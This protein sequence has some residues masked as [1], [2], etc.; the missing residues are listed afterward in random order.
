MKDRYFMSYRKHAIWYNDGIYM[1]AKGDRT[2]QIFSS[3]LEAME[4][5]DQIENAKKSTQK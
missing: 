2:D 5:I 1:V 4:W 3:Y